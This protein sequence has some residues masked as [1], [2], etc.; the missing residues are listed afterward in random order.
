VDLVANRTRG[1]MLSCR[2]QTSQ[3][4]TS[5]LGAISGVHRRLRRAARQCKGRRHAV[6]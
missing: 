4:F 2:K 1:L 3:R 5:R 6:S